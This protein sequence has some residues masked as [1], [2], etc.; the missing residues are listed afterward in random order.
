[1]EANNLFMQYI[2]RFGVEELPPRMQMP[3]EQQT[4]EFYNALLERCLKEGKLASNFITVE[5]NPEVLY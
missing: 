2:M 5:E 3:V 4:D 1:M